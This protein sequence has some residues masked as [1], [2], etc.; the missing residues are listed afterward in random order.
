MAQEPRRRS[1]PVDQHVGS[2]IRE[3]RKSLGMTQQQLA[4]ALGL[5]FQQVQK[6]E[7]GSNRVSASR[8]FETAS[9]LSTPISFFF[10]GL[11]DGLLVTEDDLGE[12]AARLFLQ[13]DEGAELARTFPRLASGRVRQKLL[14]LVRGIITAKE[15]S[16][17]QSRAPTGAPNATE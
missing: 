5:T 8:L 14:E 17:F 7:R 6:Y 11:E 3:R 15:G 13:T 10:E 2:R 4:D 1:T 12:R 16:K 9:A